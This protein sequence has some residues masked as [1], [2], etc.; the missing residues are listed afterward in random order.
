LWQTLDPARIGSP[1]PLKDT[2]IKCWYRMV[3]EAPIAARFA[4]GI[5]AAREAWFQGTNSRDCRRTLFVG[6]IPALATK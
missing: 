5:E 2:R 3:S 6:S 4:G 1:R